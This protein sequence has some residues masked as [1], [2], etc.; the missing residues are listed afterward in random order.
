MKPAV[1]TALL[2]LVAA[3]GAAA[4]ASALAH[5]S[6]A[7]AIAATATG[8]GEQALAGFAHPF[9]GFDHLL[10]MT[11]AGIW[12]V[13]QPQGAHLPKVFLAAMLLGALGGVAGVT[14][15]GLETGIAAT[16]AL[17]GALIAMAARLPAMAGA[18]MVAAF[19]VL[20]GNAH[21]HELPQVASAAGFLAASALLMAAGRWFGRAA[22]GGMVR[23]AGA[24]IAAT[25][26]LMLAA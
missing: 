12:S 6:A 10:A 7:H 22:E 3:T 11:A 21:G 24:G 20:H 15:P 16:V 1:R 26:M 8:L 5:P 25:G 14:V 23:A 13:R 19:A 17:I 9:T 4:S 18:V 2:A